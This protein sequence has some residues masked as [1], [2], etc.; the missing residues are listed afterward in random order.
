MVFM[1]TRRCL[2]ASALKFVLL[3]RILC[4]MIL[5]ELMWMYMDWCYI[6]VYQTLL[7]C[8]SPEASIVGDDV[9]KEAGTSCHIHAG[10]FCRNAGL[11]CWNAGLFCG[12]AGLF[13][14]SVGFFCGI[15][16]LVCGITGLSYCCQGGWYVVSHTH[17][18]GSSSAIPD[19]S[20]EIYDSVR[21]NA[22][23]L[24][25]ICSFFQ[26][27]ALTCYL[28]PYLASMLP[29][30]LI[31]RVTLECR[32]HLRKCRAIL[33]KCRALMRKF[34]VCHASCR[35]ICSSWEAVHDAVI[36]VTWCLAL[37]RMRSYEVQWLSLM[38]HMRCHDCHSWTDIRK[39]PAN[40]MRSCEVPWLSYEIIWGARTRTHVYR[41]SERAA[42]HD[43]FNDS[44]ICVPRFMHTHAT[45]HAWMRRGTCVNESW[46]TC[47]WVMAHV[48]MSHG[49]RVNESWHRCEWVMA[50]VCHV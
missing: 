41:R 20:V 8:V 16:G 27:R 5:Y 49:P 39:R 44:L 23:A 11:F 3:A 26:P 48:W 46:H 1:C 37:P 47:E 24:L 31:R 50:H 2:R 29:R 36:R 38:F 6:R 40:H 9:A 33:Q 10:L 21:E 15:T 43:T 4:E 45:P 7:A 22:G 18:Q 19:F 28:A 12:N 17:T 42:V 30:R 32:A 25:W 13:C 34:R 35:Y 14:G